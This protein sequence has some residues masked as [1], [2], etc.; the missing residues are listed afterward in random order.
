VV[1]KIRERARYVAN[2]LQQE[3]VGI[4]QMVIHFGGGLD[5]LNAVTLN[6]P[7]YSYAYK[8]AVFDGLL[9]LREADGGSPL[10]AAR[11]GKAGISQGSS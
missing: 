9:R 1:A 11:R 8:Y 6:T 2:L 5:D 4:G 7:T 3:L 10:K